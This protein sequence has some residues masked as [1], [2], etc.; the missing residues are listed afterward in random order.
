MKT[1]SKDT[2]SFASPMD[3]SVCWVCVNVSLQVCTGMNFWSQTG[4]HCRTPLTHVL[5]D[6]FLLY[7]VYRFFSPWISR[8]ISNHFSGFFSLLPVIMSL[9]FSSLLWRLVRSER[10]DPQHFWTHLERLPFPNWARKQCKRWKLIGCLCFVFSLSPIS[11]PPLFEGCSDF[12]WAVVS[13]VWRVSFVNSI[14]GVSAAEQQRS[15]PARVEWQ[16]LM[17]YSHGFK[18]LVS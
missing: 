4:L 1:Q 17:F 10:K 11:I 3:C 13:W 7:L 6:I 9:A 12:S 15:K 18:Q 14:V 16:M 5:P 2:V 8:S